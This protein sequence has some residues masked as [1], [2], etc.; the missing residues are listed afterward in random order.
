MAPRYTPYTITYTFVE[1]KTTSEIS[2]AYQEF[3]ENTIEKSLIDSNL[4]DIQKKKLIDRLIEYHSQSGPE[5]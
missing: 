4:S 5:T 1:K 3:Y 2:S